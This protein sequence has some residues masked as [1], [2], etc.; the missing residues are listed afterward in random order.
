M[1]LFPEAEEDY[2]ERLRKG[3][4]LAFVTFVLMAF[5]A[6]VFDFIQM[7]SSGE[8]IARY[9][10]LPSIAFYFIVILL[11]F[12]KKIKVERAF[13]LVSFGILV[14]SLI[15]QIFNESPD[16]FP[17]LVL[18]EALFI[19]LLIPVVAFMGNKLITYCMT[20][21][22]CGTITFLSFYY[23]NAYLL[24]NLPLIVGI[25]FFYSFLVS[26]LTDRLGKVL[27][28]ISL[29]RRKIKDQMEEI[30]KLNTTKDKLFSLIAHDIRG[31]LGDMMGSS[32]LLSDEYEDL[33][34]EER[35]RFAQMNYHSSVSLYT[36]IENLLN[37]SRLQFQNKKVEVKL[38]SCSTEI[39][40]T[41]ESFA[42]ELEH[43]EISINFQVPPGG[44]SLRIDAE[45]ATVVLRNLVSNAIKFTPKGGDVNICVRKDSENI[46]VE[47]AD[48]G[49]GIPEE[50][51]EIL[52][53]VTE[54][55]RRKGTGGEE[56]SGL[57]LMLCRE[58]I[59]KS[60][61]KIWAKSELNV[62]TSIFFSLPLSP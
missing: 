31:P 18:R 22:Y 46:L 29:S 3:K 44:S 1:F 60:G 17:L 12:S 41:I 23:Y 35:R 33:S 27:E 30:Q 53:D 25:L 39:K 47:I 61:G 54:K 2:Q 52:F 48:T 43:K 10:N 24:R 21:I 20:G 28:E 51:M 8:K 13:L 59:E 9:L 6:T 55:K 19:G 7:K 16:V 34:D 26:F 32:E 14:N 15:S 49:I 62:G 57:G 38:L 42:S 5:V 4:T 50:M 37:W 45:M 58:F 36:L 40:R 11:F 56:G